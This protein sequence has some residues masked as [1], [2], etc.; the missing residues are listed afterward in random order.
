MDIGKQ[1]A[2]T[3]LLIHGLGTSTL[4]FRRADWCTPVV[5]GLIAKGFRVVAMDCRGHGFSNKP[6]GS[7]NYGVQMVRDHIELMDSLRIQT[8]HVAGW[9]MGAEIAI[10][11]TTEYPDRV[12]SL[13]VYGSGW[14]YG[15]DWY[16]KSYGSFDKT[17]R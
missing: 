3:V 10:K 5:D 15:T 11:M 9:S 1:T 12:Q 13:C 4:M 2:E 14:S 8:F 6:R 17:S 7:F 16:D